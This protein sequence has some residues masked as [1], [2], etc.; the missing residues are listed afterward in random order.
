MS[1]PWDIVSAIATAIA[2]VG[3]CI[4][5]IMLV[6]Q[7]KY[8]YRKL[9]GVLMRK[10][11]KKELPDSMVLV[12]TVEFVLYN[13]GNQNIKINDVSLRLNDRLL[14]IKDTFT[15]TS[16]FPVTIEA[17]D[18]K[19]Y[20]W[21]SY[22]FEKLVSE[23]IKQNRRLKRKKVKFQIIDN[24]GNQYNV[25]TRYKHKAFFRGNLKKARFNIGVDFVAN[26][27]KKSFEDVQNDC[28]KLMESQTE[29]K[30]D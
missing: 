29:E 4:A 7:T 3:A 24:C 19:D 2:A 23:F 15:L 25:K 18:N 30:K 14:P 20:Y 5:L 26:L 11:V 28:N 1:N 22:A 27:R 10:N 6:W 13:N 21:E 16:G 9:V 12:D 17:G 8:P